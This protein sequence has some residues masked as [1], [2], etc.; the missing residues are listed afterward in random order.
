MD[1]AWLFFIVAFSYRY[2]RSFLIDIDE[3]I[4]GDILIYVDVCSDFDSI[5]DM[6]CLSCFYRYDGVASEKYIISN[7]E[8]PFSS[9]IVIGTLESTT[10]IHFFSSRGADNIGS[11]MFCLIFVSEDGFFYLTA[12]NTLWA[13]LWSSDETSPEYL[14]FLM[15]QTFLYSYIAFYNNIVFESWIG[16]KTK[17]SD[18]YIISERTVDDNTGGMNLGWHDVYCIK[19]FYLSI[20]SS[21]LTAIIYFDNMR[22]IICHCKLQRISFSL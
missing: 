6:C 19:Y 15:N 18:R 2:F 16:E 14:T 17:W 20:K 9:S 21:H 1:G 10:K 7:H 11:R 8:S 3:R 22:S 5:M 12:Y 4:S 13:Y